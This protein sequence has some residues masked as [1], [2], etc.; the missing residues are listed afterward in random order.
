MRSQRRVRREGVVLKTDGEVGVVVV[1]L[2]AILG[3]K[4][5]E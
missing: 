2:S 1:G 3:L 5:E 4:M